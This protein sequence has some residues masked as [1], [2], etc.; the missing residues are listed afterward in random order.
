M[1]KCLVLFVEGDTEV[2]FYKHVISN[3]RQKRA[4]GTFDIN[5]EYKNVRGVGGFKNIALRK[6]IK[7]IKP[8]Y[9]D[10]CEFSVALCRDTDVFEL[11]PRPPIKFDEVELAFNESGVQKVIHIEAKD[12]IE[13][14]FLL[15]INGILSF[16][17]LSKKTKASGKNGY[18]K[19]K[20]LFKQANKMYYKGMKSNGM[21]EQLNIDKIVQ[22]I[23]TELKPLYK[24]LGIY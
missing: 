9:G 11:S 10:K 6:F 4:N 8:K 7:E 15:D 24:E 12:S 1:N 16:L 2:E 17:R 5:I 14:W 23:Y 13:D 20:K 18:D 19:L 22:N 3:A 21:I